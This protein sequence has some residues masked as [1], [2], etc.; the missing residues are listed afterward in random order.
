MKTPFNGLTPAEAEA[1]TI[2]AE[3]ASEVVKA[4]M[5]ILRHGKAP[6]DHSVKPSV[7]YDNLAALQ[8]EMLDMVAAGFL[9]VT[10]GLLPPMFASPDKVAK[11]LKHQDDHGYIHHCEGFR[12]AI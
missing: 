5:K 7:T 8:G 10:E 1:L 11:R 6:T 9:C 2:L 4:A 12:N 3:E